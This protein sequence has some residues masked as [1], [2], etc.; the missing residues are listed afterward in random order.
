MHL[1]GRG[2]TEGDDQVTGAGGF[3]ERS[4]GGSDG[5]LVRDLIVECSET[6]EIISFSSSSSFL[7]TFDDEGLT[8]KL[9]NNPAVT[10]FPRHSFNPV[11]G[12][13]KR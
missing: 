12:A 11:L 1:T 9:F 2:E 6:I 4:T 7:C 13:F 8:I 3:G 10:S 5:G